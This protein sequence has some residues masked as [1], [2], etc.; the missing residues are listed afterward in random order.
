MVVKKSLPVER[1]LWGFVDVRVTKMNMKNETVAVS[2]FSRMTEWPTKNDRYKEIVSNMTTL[3]F[4]VTE[5]SRMYWLVTEGENEEKDMRWWCEDHKQKLFKDDVDEDH[6]SKKKV[7]AC[8]NSRRNTMI[9]N[10]MISSQNLL[11]RCWEKS[12][13]SLIQVVN[14]SQP[15]AAPILF[16][17]N[18]HGQASLTL[19]DT[20]TAT[21]LL[22]ISN[23]W[24]LMNWSS[25]AVE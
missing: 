23:P 10:I 20:T 11:L 6:A 22:I 25:M 9:V 18:L 14:E 15:P 12:C 13:F 5:H 3:N 21:L 24:L 19:M 8:M 16:C 4:Q 7:A 17:E 2:K 1:S